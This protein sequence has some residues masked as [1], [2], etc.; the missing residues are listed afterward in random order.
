VCLSSHESARLGAAVEVFG[1]L[2]VVDPR[3]DG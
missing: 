3:R 2:V 1:S